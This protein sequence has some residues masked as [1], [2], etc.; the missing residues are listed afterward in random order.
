MTLE[1]GT[2]YFLS[3]SR[4]SEVIIMS[5]HEDLVQTKGKK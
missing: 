1:D 2:Y 5:L 3:F 4:S